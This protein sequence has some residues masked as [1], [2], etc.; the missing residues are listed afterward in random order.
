MIRLSNWSR[1]FE[2]P[3]AVQGL[4]KLVLR[5]HKGRVDFVLAGGFGVVTQGNSLVTRDVDVAC[6]MEPDNLVKVY[7]AFE[8]IREKLRGGG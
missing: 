4:K 3:S 1:S 6:R 5:L 8:A 7:R 2:P